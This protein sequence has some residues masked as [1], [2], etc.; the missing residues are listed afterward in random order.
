MIKIITLN[1]NGLKSLIR[2]NYLSHFIKQYHPDILNL[3]E[4]NIN[5]INF[6]D[7]E[8]DAIINNNIENQKSGTII[9][10]K[11][12]LELLSQEKSPD[13]R[14]IRAVFKNLTI[15]NL[16]A[17]TQRDEA[18]K[19][20]TF[21]IN[22]LPT[23]IKPSDKKLIITGDFNSIIEPNDRTGEEKRINNNLRYYR[24]NLN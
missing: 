21:F 7:S 15:I 6:I 2:Q 17:P 8:Y 14:I 11:K 12:S 4:T 23:Y 13:G 18:E 16:Y 20:N 5:N 22:T 3:Q 10:F 1:I 24:R 9:I 19:R